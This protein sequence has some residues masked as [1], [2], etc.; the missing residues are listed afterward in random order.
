[1]KNRIDLISDLKKLLLQNYDDVGLSIQDVYVIKEPLE[2]MLHPW[3]PEDGDIFYMTGVYYGGGKPVIYGPFEIPVSEFRELLP[4]DFS[5][6]DLPEFCRLYLKRS[7]AFCAMFINYG[8]D[9]AIAQIFGVEEARPIQR[10]HETL[11]GTDDCPIGY[12]TFYL[13]PDEV[14]M[15]VLT[16]F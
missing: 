7:L 5:V 14:V 12:S 2:G 13:H 4:P 8:L 16:K 1:M 3:G 6:Q 9:P 15:P 10:W 11:V